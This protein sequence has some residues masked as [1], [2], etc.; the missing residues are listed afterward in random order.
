MPRDKLGL[1]SIH[2][3][4]LNKI[5]S[6]TYQLIRDDIH[7]NHNHTKTSKID[8]M[9]ASTAFCVPDTQT[10]SAFSLNMKY[11]NKKKYLGELREHVMK[12][13]ATFQIFAFNF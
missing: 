5:P 4:N 9:K 3:V 12:Q 11:F 7:L 6:E 13:L 1:T 8:M 10:K 2:E